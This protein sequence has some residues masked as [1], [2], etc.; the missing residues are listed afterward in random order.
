VPVIVQFN[1]LLQLSQAIGC[2]DERN[3]HMVALVLF[4]ILQD[5]IAYEMYVQIRQPF[6][7]VDSESIEVGRPIGPYSPDKWNQRQFGEFCERYYRGQ[8]GANGAAFRISGVRDLIMANNTFS[9]GPMVC[10]LAIP[11]AGSAAW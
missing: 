6:G 10:E 2:S 5:Q 9:T 7:T 11:A 1:R 4:T 8:I 3:N